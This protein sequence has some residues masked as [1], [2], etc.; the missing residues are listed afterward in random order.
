MAR[1]AGL[2]TGYLTAAQ[3]LGLSSAGAQQQRLGK[4]AAEA[5]QQTLFENLKEET[6]QSTKDGLL[7]AKNK[8]GMDY[9]R[10]EFEMATEFG[11]R[12]SRWNLLRDKVN[13]RIVYVNVD[14]LQLV[15]GKT[16]ICEFCGT[17]FDPPDIKCKKCDRKRS[18]KNQKLYR[19][20]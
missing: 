17:V 16:A 6:I 13:H 14:T 9:V 20:G 5:A 10:K 12:I 1:Q 7:E 2:P 15:S 8:R 18:G 3:H 11:A 4:S 19:K